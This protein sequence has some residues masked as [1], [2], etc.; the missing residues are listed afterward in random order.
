MEEQALIFDG[1]NEVG[2]VCKTISHISN[3][4]YNET[5]NFDISRMFI[6]EQFMIIFYTFLNINEYEQR[7]YYKDNY[8]E[9]L[10]G[11][12]TFMSHKSCVRF[13]ARNMGFSTINTNH[14]MYKNIS[15]NKF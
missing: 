12:I 2:M 14:I 6:I 9:K 15:E 3:S 8:A 7:G 11:K 4:S 13:V 5:W 10:R 1:N